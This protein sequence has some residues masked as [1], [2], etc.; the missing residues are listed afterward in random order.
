MKKNTINNS[1][2][3]NNLPSWAKIILP[4]LGVIFLVT[5]GFFSIHQPDGLL[6]K[7]VYPELIEKV[8]TYCLLGISAIL[9]ILFI[10]IVFNIQLKSVQ[11][12]LIL[13]LGIIVGIVISNSNTRVILLG[14]I[15]DAFIFIVIITLLELYSTV[16]TMFSLG[17][18]ST[19]VIGIVLLNIPYYFERPSAAIYLIVTIY[20]VLYQ[21]IGVKLNKFFISRIMGQAERSESFDRKLLKMHMMLIY[22]V[23]FILINATGL[24]Y[25]QDGINYSN[26]VNNCFITAITISQINWGS[27]LKASN[28]SLG[29]KII[30]I[31]SREEKNE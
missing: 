12:T 6:S 7:M 20:L 30:S 31:V 10:F 13:I 18:L 1:I 17:V 8:I 19:I 23:I 3:N 9:G 16:M 24:L 15:I 28:F 21:F 2:F 27:L 22:T 14:L 25:E 5:A 4:L 26:I 11:M 29:E